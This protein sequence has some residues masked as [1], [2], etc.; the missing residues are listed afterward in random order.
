M[1]VATIILAGTAA[2]TIVG[3]A[4]FA[5]QAATGTITKIDRINNTI[6]IQQTQ[7]G[8]VGANTASAAED[9]KVQTGVSLNDWHAGDKVSYSATETGGKKTITKLEKQ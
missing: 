6:A 1:K 5:D 9:F 8:T 7:S 4:A 3:S 2:L